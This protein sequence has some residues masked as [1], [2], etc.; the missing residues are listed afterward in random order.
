[1]NNPANKNKENSKAIFS[2]QTCFSSEYKEFSLA[3]KD[4]LLEFIIKNTKENCPVKVF[5]NYR[6]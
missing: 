3:D 6:S 2:V 5:V 4:K 1:M